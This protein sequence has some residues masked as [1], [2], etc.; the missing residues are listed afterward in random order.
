[1]I[2]TGTYQ[3][4]HRFLL[5]IT[6]LCFWQVVLSVWWGRADAEAMKWFGYKSAIIWHEGLGPWLFASQLSSM[7]VDISSQSSAKTKGGAWVPISVWQVLGSTLPF[8]LP[9]WPGQHP[10]SFS[11]SWRS[12]LYGKMWRSKILFCDVCPRHWFLAKKMD[13]FSPHKATWL[14]HST[15]PNSD[16]YVFSWM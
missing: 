16:V 3:N 2:S 14:F 15:A 5:F 9:F 13:P 7:N 8:S 4:V 10:C 11:R 12:Q 1:M 6:P